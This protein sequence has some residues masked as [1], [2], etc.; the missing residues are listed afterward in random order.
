M[1]NKM[2]RHNVRGF[3]L[4]ELL[5]VVLVLAV[6]SLVAI[7][8]YTSQ[9]KSAAARACKANLTAISSSLAGYALRNGRYPTTA[10]G[11]VEL[12]GK[13]EGLT[14]VPVCPL[15]KS[16]YT[17]SVSSGIG[18]LE[19]PNKANTDHTNFGAT[20]AELSRTLAAPA[21]DQLP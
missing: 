15:D 9:R 5:A 6:L 2:R 10:E 8:L 4:V 17:W 3:S 21:A 20:T 19:C 18:T 16:A 11:L 12:V 14:S 7:P 13:A 1:V